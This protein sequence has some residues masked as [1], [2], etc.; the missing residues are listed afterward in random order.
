MMAF[1]SSLHPDH[2]HLSMSL[3]AGQ[4]RRRLLLDSI[5][6]AFDSVAPPI[7]MSDP[8]SPLKARMSMIRPIESTSSY[9]NNNNNEDK[10]KSKT[11]LKSHSDAEIKAAR[12]TFTILADSILGKEKE[13]KSKKKMEQ[14]IEKMKKEQEEKIHA[15]AMNKPPPSSRQKVSTK[16]SR[17]TTTTTGSR[18][19]FT[20]YSRFSNSSTSS[21]LPLIPTI[22]KTTTYSPVTSMLKAPD[23]I[24]NNSSH[25]EAITLNKVYT[26]DKPNLS[27]KTSDTKVKVAKNMLKT[28]EKGMIFETR[29][30]PDLFDEWIKKRNE[31]L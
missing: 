18:R 22:M 9:N 7:D 16:K 6:T 17:I 21:S 29:K 27:V 10:N 23:P 12:D 15:M 11:K 26:S 5:T 8:L 13:M 24:I 2:N 25:C 19:S 1:H 3:W 4:Q 31:L 28:K 14:E 20:P 30:K